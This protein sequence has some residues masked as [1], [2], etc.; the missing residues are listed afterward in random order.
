MREP[1]TISTSVVCACAPNGWYGE[2][3][4]T[5]VVPYNNAPKQLREQANT[6]SFNADDEGG[7]LSAEFPVCRVP[8]LSVDC[9]GQKGSGVYVEGVVKLFEIH[10]LARLFRR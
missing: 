2:S 6:I 5:V 3:F 1:I 9:Q 10:M 4:L 8:A 7:R